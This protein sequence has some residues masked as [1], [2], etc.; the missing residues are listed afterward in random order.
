MAQITKSTIFNHP[1]YTLENGRY[2]AIIVTGYG[3]NIIELYDKE[4]DIHVFRTPDTADFNEFSKSPQHF[5][6]AILF[7]PNRISG[8]TFTKHDRKYNFFNQPTVGDFSHGLLRYLPFKVTH[9]QVSGENI[10]LKATYRSSPEADTIY[11]DF[12]HE[13]LCEVTFS[14][15]SRGLYE[16]ISFTNFGY[17]PMPLGVG[18][19]TA[20]G[21]PFSP[22][23]LKSDYRVMFTADKMLPLNQNRVPTG[24]F[25]A[26]DA[27]YTQPE[28]F[29][30]LSETVDI[31][32]TVKTL[33]I[34]KV[35]F[36]GAKITNIRNG[37]T[38]SFEISDSF[39]FW[40]AWN[41]KTVNNYICIEPMSWCI[42]APNS[43]LDDRETGYLELSRGM[44]WEGKLSF[45]TDQSI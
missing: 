29:D 44:N 37:K 40:M 34:D 11:K 13:F 38:I 14:L 25:L 4:L 1:S 20:F 5:G 8:G 7:P 17:E 23:T 18:F 42:D 21:I 16:T 24:S 9:D 41:N 28:G 43:H 39:P 45:R 30:P 2:K 26:C 36:R 33:F 31:H 35:P 3:A 15:T 10:E 12:P 32:T 22:N 27:R 19:H 6:N